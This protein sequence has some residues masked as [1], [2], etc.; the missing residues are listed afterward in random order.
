MRRS[1]IVPLALAGLV[2]ISTNACYGK[3]SL[4]RKLYAWNGSVGDKW[5]KSLVLVLLFIVPAYEI[6]GLVDYL[7]LNVLEFWTGKNPA[8]MNLGESETRIVQHEGQTFE[9]TATKDRFDIVKRG[10]ASDSVHDE[11]V[12]LRF[13]RSTQA[14]FVESARTGERK[15]GQISV[16]GSLLKVLGANGEIIAESGI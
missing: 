4:T 16:D 13:D 3:F 5:L 8:V 1:V 12:A 10:E 9:I 7:L 15:V 14:W 2:A 6:A 11:H